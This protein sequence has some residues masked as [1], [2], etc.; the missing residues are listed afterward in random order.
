MVI[1]GGLV[2]QVKTRQVQNG[3]SKGHRMGQFTLEDLDGTVEAVAFPS[4]WKEISSLLNVDRLV[5]VRGR[6]SFRN[7]E[8][9]VRVSAVI[10]IEE[11]HERLTSELVIMLE[12]DAI[13]DA[14]LDA[15][16]A[17]IVENL[18]SCPLVIQVRLDDQRQATIQAGRDFRV[19][20][21]PELAQGLR[22][23]LGAH[24]LN[25]AVKFRPV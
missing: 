24:G 13:D 21:S 15:L 10:P 1:L 16:R 22:E 8:P 18:G 6:L 9:S 12:R 20:P 19:R 3:R 5:F 4:E 25:G 23:I 11:A 7:G 17:V 2:Q 14:L